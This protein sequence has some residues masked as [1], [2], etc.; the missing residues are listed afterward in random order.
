M[1]MKRISLSRFGQ[2]SWLVLVFMVAVCVA[3]RPAAADEPIKLRVAVYAGEG[4][5][6]CLKDM[7]KALA[8]K[9]ELKVD[10]FKAEDLDTGILKGFDVLVFPGG[11][12]GGQGK[13]LGE[14]RR[15]QIRSFVKE[16][17]G[18][19][20]V[21]AG[22]YLA[23]CDYSWSLGLLNAKVIDKK[24]WARG[25]GDV[26]IT[27]DTK[28]QGVIGRS[29]PK[30]TI[31]YYQGPLLAPGDNKELP[32][33]QELAKFKT[34]IAKNGAPAGIMTGSTAI[35][36]APFGKGRVLAFSPHPELTEGLADLLH[37][38]IEWAAKGSRR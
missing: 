36:A 25:Y 37:A 10:R 12:G 16:G 5:S 4:T 31:R 17:G 24:H 11:T 14:P 19:V 22:A 33:Y 3:P 7:L 8:L 21:C 15:E 34:E 23:T 9:P 20:G 35:A 38:G 27:L 1:T 13:A 26:E 28:A 18:F 29:E 32:P 30:L 2:Q 6:K